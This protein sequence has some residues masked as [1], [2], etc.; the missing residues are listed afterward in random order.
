MHDE[1]T[2]V[3]SRITSGFDGKEYFYPQL[4]EDLNWV[5]SELQE[6]IGSLGDLEANE[7]GLYG[8]HLAPKLKKSLPSTITVRVYDPSY[9]R[10]WPKEKHEHDCV[11]DGL[12]WISNISVSEE[13]KKN[14][15]EKKRQLKLFSRIR[16]WDIWR[17]RYACDQVID[18]FSV[19]P[20]SGELLWRSASQHASG[21]SGLGSYP[22]N[23]YV[24]LTYVGFVGGGLLLSRP[25]YN[26]N[27]E[28]G[29]YD[30]VADKSA[31]L[32]ALALLIMNSLPTDTRLHLSAS[33][34]MFMHYGFD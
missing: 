19:H 18:R 15:V 13:A 9:S 12:E 11:F 31:T 28:N 34:Q 22:F 1:R 8:L 20:E 4:E 32:R 16:E 10:G 33:R 25:Y 21:I 2:A 5:P 29:D 27:T 30:P 14:G 26:P 3:I 23:E 17:F 6:A 7:D 24:R